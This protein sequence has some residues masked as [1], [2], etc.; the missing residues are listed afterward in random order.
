MG[1][2]VWF[3]SFINSTVYIMIMAFIITEKSLRQINCF[4][5]FVRSFVRN[6]ER[7]T[8]WVGTGVGGQWRRW[9]RNFRRRI[10]RK[11]IRWDDRFQLRGDGCH[12][13]LI[14]N[15]EAVMGK[16]FDRASLSIGCYGLVRLLFTFDKP[17][18]FVLRI[19]KWF[20]WKFQKNQR[21]TS[22]FWFTAWTLFTWHSL[23]P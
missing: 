15:S 21:Q 6:K 2:R 23:P 18:C 8:L 1:R 5:L 20:T 7:W 19:L 10:S 14:F 9:K 11:W 16:G 12:G 22:R 13:I 4:R 3:K 17:M